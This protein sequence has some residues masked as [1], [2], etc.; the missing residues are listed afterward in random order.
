MSNAVL[1]ISDIQ[2]AD[3]YS[4]TITVKT[5][6]S[7]NYV[8]T[9]TDV[10]GSY[11]TPNLK[12]ESGGYAPT[13]SDYFLGAHPVGSIYVSMTSSNPGNTY[14]GTWMQIAQGQTLVGVNTSDSRFNT[15]GTTGGVYSQALI[16]KIGHIDG[17]LGKI[18]WDTVGS[19]ETSYRNCSWIRGAEYGNVEPHAVNDATMVKTTGDAE[20]TT[21]QPY[22]T[23][24][25][26]KRTA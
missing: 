5:D 26:W 10:N 4:P 1:P 25:F 21:I 19:T 20:P 3:G 8:L 23:T 11:N 13:A 24:Y 18:G 7:T 9:I 15:A 22:C 2:G 12:G 14:G 16:A 17:D 6:T